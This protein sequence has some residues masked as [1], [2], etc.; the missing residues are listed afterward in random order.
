MKLPQ[1]RLR[2]LLW[3]TSLVA[4]LL[5]IHPV[6]IWHEHGMLIIALVVIWWFLAWE[7]GR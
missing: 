4:I 6:A 5:A 7:A 3:V 2:T 1:F